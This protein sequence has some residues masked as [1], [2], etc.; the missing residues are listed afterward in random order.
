MTSLDE[1]RDSLAALVALIRAHDTLH[2]RVRLQKLGYLLQ[3]MGF[4]PLRHVRFSYHHYGPYSDQLAGVLDQAVAS[5]LVVEHVQTTAEQRRRFMY[6]VE[7]QHEDL[8]Q[9]DLSPEQVQALSAFHEATKAYHWRTLELA[10]TVIYLERRSELTRARALERALG[11]KP[12]CADYRDEAMA[13]LGSLG[14]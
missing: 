14:L 1:I 3:Q 6:E 7:P 9:L 12:A 2:G 4:A 10:A 5:G 8:S 11:L 13:L